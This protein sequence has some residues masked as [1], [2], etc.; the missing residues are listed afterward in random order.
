MCCEAA[1]F[2][3]A[4]KQYS[5]NLGNSVA[6]FLKHNE[7]SKNLT[8]HSDPSLQGPFAAFCASQEQERL[9]EQKL[10]ELQERSAKGLGL[11]LGC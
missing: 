11:L 6:F 7:H 8:D 9:Q 4:D 1:P 3:F 10:Q 5:L 2:F